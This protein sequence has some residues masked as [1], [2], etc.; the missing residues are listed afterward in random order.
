MNKKMNNFP[1]IKGLKW[2]SD[3]FPDLVTIDVTLLSR[4]IQELDIPGM[5]IPETPSVMYIDLSKLAGVNPWYPKGADDPS[6]TECSVDVNGIANFV[7]DI[8]LENLVEA[9]LFYKQFKYKHD[10]RNI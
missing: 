5:A 1:K 9:W 10:T 3:Q 7:A 8:R 4:T 6:E 2:L